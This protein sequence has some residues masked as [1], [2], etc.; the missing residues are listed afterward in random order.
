MASIYYAQPMLGVLGAR[1]APPTARSA[2]CPRSR[3]WAMRWA[4][5]CSA[6]LGDRYDRRRIILA[7]AALLAAALLLGGAAHAIGALLVASLV[8]RPGRD[9]AQDIVPAAATLAPEAHRGQGG[10][11]RDD[12]PAAGHPAVAA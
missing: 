6:P 5:C 3:S 10:R 7:K 1:S 2:S 12:R 4:S 11:H 9:L 8:D